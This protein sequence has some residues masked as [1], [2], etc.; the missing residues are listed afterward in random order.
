MDWTGGTRRRFAAKGKGNGILRKQKAHFAKVRAGEHPTLTG[1]LREGSA[2]RQIR[3]SMLDPNGINDEETSR[4]QSR[5]QGSGVARP[6]VGHGQ[7]AT[8]RRFPSPAPRRRGRMPGIT[9]HPRAETALDE[10]SKRTTARQQLLARSDWLGLEVTRPVKMKFPSNREQDRVG[11]RRKIEKQHI[12]KTIPA[13]KQV[14]S[15]IDGIKT[16]VLEPDSVSV[17]DNI[18]IRIGTDAFASQ[19]QRSRLF[20]TPPNPSLAPPSTAFSD[21]SMLLDAQ[22]YASEARFNRQ[23]GAKQLQPQAGGHWQHSSVEFES[24]PPHAVQADAEQS[25]RACSEASFESLTNREPC[26]PGLPTIE[27]TFSSEEQWSLQQMDQLVYPTM[28]DDGQDTAHYGRAEPRQLVPRD[29][30]DEEQEVNGDEVEAESEA[31]DDELLWKRMMH[32]KQTESSDASVVAVRSSSEHLT[33]P[34]EVLNTDEEPANELSHRIYQDNRAIERLDYTAAEI[35]RSPLKKAVQEN[36]PERLNFISNDNE[37][38]EDEDEDDLWRKFVLGST[39]TQDSSLAGR[40]RQAASDTE[41]I[42]PILKPTSCPSEEHLR[43]DRATL[44]GSVYHVGTQPD[45]ISQARQSDSRTDSSSEGQTNTSM[46]D[47]TTTL[48][49]DRATLG[50]SLYDTGTQQDVTSHAV[51]TDSSSERQTNTSMIGHATTAGPANEDIDED[52]EAEVPPPRTYSR[53]SRPPGSKLDPR[54]FKQSRKRAPY[55]PLPR[56]VPRFLPTISTATTP[57]TKSPYDLSD[58]LSF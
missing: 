17:D 6:K 12:R 45:N 42:L 53:P 24:F 2:T 54:R 41:S 31:E 36:L 27:G 29:V 37:E 4:R 5:S 7:A 38:D 55:A 26:S 16:R 18:R 34:T 49:S 40:R 35:P 44:G 3:P 47:H 46:V 52:D 14:F 43:S 13:E 19:T 22:S 56:V 32:I 30:E 21:E 20:C 8:S 1:R 11:K 33:Q 39:S 23:V 57:A 48:R 15:H 50:G 25:Q 58:S 9:K 10:E 51:S 28:L